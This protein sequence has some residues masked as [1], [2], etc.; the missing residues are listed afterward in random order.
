MWAQLDD[1]AAGRPVGVGAPPAPTPTG[2]RRSAAASVERHSSA[3]LV[4]PSVGERRDRRTRTE[5][6][7]LAGL[8]PRRSTCSAA[9]RVGL[10]QEHVDVA[11]SAQTRSIRRRYGAIV[12]RPASGRS[13]DS[14]LAG[15]GRSPTGARGDGRERSHDGRLPSRPGW[16]S[17]DPPR[18]RGAPVSQR[19]SARGRSRRHRGRPRPA[20]AEY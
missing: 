3:P 15:V 10:G 13:F 19:E 5:R 7:R 8:E 2:P 1:A 18:R 9:A 12:P 17:T 6:E 14:A 16:D 20:R 11:V 4:R